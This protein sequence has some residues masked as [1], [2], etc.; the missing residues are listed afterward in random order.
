MKNKR[1]ISAACVIFAGVLWGLMGIFVR[2]FEKIELNSMTIVGIRVS[3]TAV[4]LG[5]LLLIYDRK[6]FCIRLRDCWCFIGTG[7]VSIIMFSFCYFT[8]MT[9]TSLSVAAVLLYTEPIMVMLMAAV[10]FKEKLT[11]KSG[12][13][14]MIA[15]IGCFFVAGIIGEAQSISAKALITGLLSA[16]GYGLYS[17]FGRYALNKSYHPLTIAFSACRICLA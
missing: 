10:L 17:I 2:Y 3:V 9:Y 12:I 6:L 4:I 13:A 16:F 15:F 8:T 5:I 7:M 14:A 11:I 1:V